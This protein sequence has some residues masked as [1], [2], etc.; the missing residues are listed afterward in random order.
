MTQN[1]IAYLERA[2]SIACDA[3]KGQV[4]KSG[5]PYI[6]HPLRVMQKFT[7]YDEMITAILHDVIEDSS[8][9]IEDLKSFGFNESV[10]NALNLLTKSNEDSYSEYIERISSNTLATRIKIADLK[11]NLDITRLSNIS[12]SDM[13]RAKK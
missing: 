1:K 12:D 8:M 13:Q 4:D 9:S 2:I 7:D 11:D 6:L 5:E 3:H 10:T